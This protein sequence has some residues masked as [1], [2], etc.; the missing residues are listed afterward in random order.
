MMV[1]DFQ[2]VIGN[3]RLEQMPVDAGRQPDYIVASVGGGS[4]AMGIFHPYIDHKNVQ[5]IGVES[6][7]DGLETGRHAASLNAGVVGALHGHRTYVMHDEHGQVKAT[8]SISDEL[9]YHGV[10]PAQDWL[11][12]PGRERKSG[13]ER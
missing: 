5:L 10:G 4:N 12:E 11:K 8:H 3:E 2:T 7:G 1:R 6:A 13:A 9:D